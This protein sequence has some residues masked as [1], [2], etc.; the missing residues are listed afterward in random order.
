MTTTGGFGAG[1]V[2]EGSEPPTLAQLAELAGTSVATVSKVVNGRSEVAPATRARVEELIRERGYRRQKKAANRAALVELVF[3]ELEGAYAMEI[4]KGVGAVAR[5][6]GLAVVLSESQG[7]H[8]PGRGWAEGVMRR[9][10]TGVIAVFSELTADQ[11]HQLAGRG[12]PTVLVDPTGE[13][14]HA[15]P[16]VGAGNWNGG[17]LAVRHLLALGHRRI[18]IVTGPA[19]VLSSRARLDG[20]RAALDAAGVPVDP[21]LVREGD[22]HVADGLRHARALL[23]LPEPPTAVF[24]CNDLQALGVYRAA[25]EAG[26][27]VPGD[28]SVVGFDDLPAAEWAVPSLTTVRQPLSDMGAAAVTMIVAL[29]RGEALP[30]E[31]VELPTTLITRASTAAPPRR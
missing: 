9:R 14:G 30:Q 8:V 17:L 12:I 11:S 27:R 26:L 2:A 19:D 13:P 24:A 7:R 22:F 4:I 20:Y 25:H 18:A 23:A 6:H 21:A 15:F 31:R 29:A 28:L 1:G 3:H 5:R 10:P 16:S